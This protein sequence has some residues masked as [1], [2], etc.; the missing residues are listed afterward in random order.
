MTEKNN[1]SYFY[2]EIFMFKNYFILKHCQ[3][4][5]N[6]QFCTPIKLKVGS[7]DVNTR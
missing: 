4:E 2:I 7:S 5:N 1:I 3:R 6:M